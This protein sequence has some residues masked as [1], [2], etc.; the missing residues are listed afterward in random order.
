MISYKLLTV[1]LGLL[2]AQIRLARSHAVIVDVVGD[3]GVHGIGFGMVSSVPRDG[4]DEQPFQIDT[5]VF[6]NLVDDPCGSTLAG[7]SINIAGS[8]TA[9]EKAGKGKLP[10][11]TSEFVTRITLHQVNGDGGGPFTAMFNTD[12]TGL[13]WENATVV[14]QAPGENGLLV[15]GPFDSRF[16]AQLPRNTRCTGGTD[17]NVC[18]IRVSNGGAAVGAGPF[19]GCFAVQMPS[20]TTDRNPTAGKKPTPTRTPAPSRNPGEGPAQGRNPTTDTDDGPNTNNGNNRNGRNQDRAPR[21]FDGLSQLKR[22]ISRLIRRLSISPS[23]ANDLIT[24]SGSALNVPI[25]LLAGQDDASP[26]GGNSTTAKNAL[27]TVQEAEKLK[28]D[29]KDAISK[30]IQMM[31]TGA[32]TP[33]AGAVATQINSANPDLA[34]TRNQ[35]MTASFSAGL[36]TFTSQAVG[37]PAGTATDVVASTTRSKAAVNPTSTST[38][39]NGGNRNGQNRNGQGRDGQNRNGQDG[40]GQNRNNQ[41]GNHQNGNGNNQR[42]VRLPRVRSRIMRDIAFAE[43]E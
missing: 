20:G 26:N 16:E 21:Q 32:V 22:D 9:S 36:A 25:D 24:A 39:G 29:V 28:A 35:E 19:G 31:A 18:L 17:K 5:A 13:T 8:L 30:A 43:A 38:R 34:I 12:G 3:N 14:T 10:S 23:E 40:N 15:G 2:A 33:T 1:S 41:N 7:G 37:Q 6:K 4:T 27:L 42:G 11:L